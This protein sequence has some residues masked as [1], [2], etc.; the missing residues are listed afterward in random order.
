MERLL[1]MCIYIWDIWEAMYGVYGFVIINAYIEFFV[2]DLSIHDSILAAW[3]KRKMFM[4]NLRI[5]KEIKEEMDLWWMLEIL[6]LWENI[7]RGRV[8][9]PIFFNDIITMIIM[10]LLITLLLLA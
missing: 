1:R 2:W 3:I 10:I 7:V 8:M 4:I 9:L 6:E 5:I